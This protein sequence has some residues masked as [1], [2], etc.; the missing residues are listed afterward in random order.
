MMGFILYL[1]LFILN[2]VVAFV[3]VERKITLDL[4]E[5]EVNL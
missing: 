2:S 1:Y 5:V 4:V 3:P